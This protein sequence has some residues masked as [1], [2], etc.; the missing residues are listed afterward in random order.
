MNRNYGE[1]TEM[2]D[3][4]ASGKFTKG[5]KANPGGRERTDLSLSALIDEAV[6]KEDWVFIVKA[7]LKKARRGDHKSIEWLS[8]RRFGKAIQPTDNKHSGVIEVVI[9]WDDVG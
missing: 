9:N 3:R 2:T 1:M 8:D 5:N 4:D 7:Q 6:T